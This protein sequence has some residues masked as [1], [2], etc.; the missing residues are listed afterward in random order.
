MRVCGK[1]GGRQILWKIIYLLCDFIM[2]HGEGRV[3]N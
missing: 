1:R 2:G 3:T